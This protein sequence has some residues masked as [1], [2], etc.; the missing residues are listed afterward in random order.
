MA[1]DAN[2]P[3]LSD[4][5]QPDA[6]KVAA[7]WGRDRQSERKH[8]W[9]DHPTSLACINQRR[10]QNPEMDL[11]AYWRT[12]FF[13]GPAP[14]ALSLGCGFG[15]W[16][17]IALKSNL[18]V[19]IE[20]YDVSADAIAGA[21]KA[22]IDEG[23]SGR[24]DYHVADVNTLQLAP[25]RYDA[26]FGISSLHHVEAL[27]HLFAQSKVALKP[28]GLF[29]ID[30][31]V[32]PARFQSNPRVVE[33]INT[34]LRLLPERYRRSIYLN[35]EI[36]ETYANTPLSWF[37]ETDP[38]EA[39]RSDAIL[40]CLKEH[41]EIVDYKPYGGALMHMLLSGIAGNFDPEVEEDAA[42][43]RMLAFFEQ[44]LEKTGAIGTD[45]ATVVARPRF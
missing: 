44:E 10:A 9:L 23:L 17:R 34:L 30:E 18:A 25:G 24:I 31:Y 1:D 26:I 42:L 11:A 27:E 39:V 35:N 41:F 19:L 22:A 21:R 14:M 2:P 43:I 7:F 3:I 5:D 37:D 45:F 15:L 20:A 28:N 13:P 38:S 8:N 40:P 32:G 16:E 6:A 12:S 4:G 29:F 33:L 36:R